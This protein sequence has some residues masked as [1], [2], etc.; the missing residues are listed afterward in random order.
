[1]C[2]E[3]DPTRC[4]AV[5][6]TPSHLRQDGCGGDPA[7]HPDRRGEDQEGVRTVKRTLTPT[8]YD[9]LGAKNSTS[10]ER[11]MGAQD[12]FVSARQE[13]RQPSH[14]H[15][16]ACHS[17]RSRLLLP[18][19]AHRVPRHCALVTPFLTHTAHPRTSRPASQ[20][21]EGRHSS[22]PDLIRAHQPQ[23]RDSFFAIAS[24][25]PYSATMSPSFGGF[26]LTSSITFS[27]SSS[28]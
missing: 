26:C 25:S 22:V 11:C 24:D 13:H 14:Q 23:R 2:A 7:A 12:T 21:H 1:V 6:A 20:Q 15:L 16:V 4:S 19:P 3:P 5:R 9:I 28:S 27:R 18:S 17:V 10:I 8:S